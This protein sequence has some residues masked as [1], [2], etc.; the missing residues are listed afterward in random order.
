MI[1]RNGVAGYQGYGLIRFRDAH[2][3]EAAIDKEQRDEE[4]DGADAR[5][6]GL[7]GQ[8]HRD[9]DGQQAGALPNCYWS[10]MPALPQTARSASVATLNNSG[11]VS[12]EFLP[13]T[14]RCGSSVRKPS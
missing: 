12:P 8:G 5:L 4:E 9:L 2:A 11:P 10:W 13:A 3:V 6:Q 7:I 1:P 14:R